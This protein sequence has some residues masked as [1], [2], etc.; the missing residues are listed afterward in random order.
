[1][2]TGKTKVMVY[3]YNHIKYPAEIKF[4][5]VGT[6]EWEVG[7]FDNEAENMLVT[8]FNDDARRWHLNTDWEDE[9][10]AENYDDYGVLTL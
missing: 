3:V 4:A 9:S 7:H 5:V 10:L 1:M 2:T 6:D 8:L